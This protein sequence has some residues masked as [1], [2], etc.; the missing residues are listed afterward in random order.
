MSCSY[1]LHAHVAVHPAEAA[2]RMVAI[3]TQLEQA[4]MLFAHKQD[5]PG[6]A[7]QQVGLQHVLKD[8]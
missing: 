3:V 7:A 2:R 1:T 4:L 6:T 5:G 8:V